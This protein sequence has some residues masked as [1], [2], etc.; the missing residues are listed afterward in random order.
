LKGGVLFIYFKLL[1]CINKIHSDEIYPPS[2]CTLP[3]S[4]RLRSVQL[5]SQPSLLRLY[6]LPNPD[7]LLITHSTPGT[8]IT[9]ASNPSPYTLAL[10]DVHNNV[11]HYAITY[12]GH[13]NPSNSTELA[14][15]IQAIGNTSTQFVFD[16]QVHGATAIRQINFALLI[17]GAEGV[18]DIE[19]VTL[20]KKCPNTG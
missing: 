17:V 2:P 19:V 15:R 8:D 1:F 5:R 3:P 18:G 7:Q 13:W 6:P 16:L 20:S 12:S 14:F 10:G 9:N 11:D 4:L